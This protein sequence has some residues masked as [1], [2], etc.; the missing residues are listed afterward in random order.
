[1]YQNKRHEEFQ[2]QYLFTKQPDRWSVVNLLS[3]SASLRQSLNYR[4]SQRWAWQQKFT[5][6]SILCSTSFYVRCSVFCAHVLERECCSKVEL[7]T[8]EFKY[9]VWVVSTCFMFT[10]WV[11]Q[12]Y[13]WVFSKYFWLVQIYDLVLILT[14]NAPVITTSTWC[15]LIFF[16]FQL[17]HSISCG[18]ASTH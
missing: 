9:I 17:P 15:E 13:L 5:R 14:Q 10:A 18:P 2:L 6:D 7:S 8:H 1:M 4:S 11:K 16:F 3:H 12:I